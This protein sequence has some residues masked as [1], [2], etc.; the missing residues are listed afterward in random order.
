[1][2]DQL[3]LVSIIQRAK[4]GDE[5]AMEEIFRHFAPPL[6]R[7]LKGRRVID[8]EDIASDTWLSVVSSL[9]K[10]QGDGSDFRAWI[11]STARRRII[12]SARRAS[13]RPKLEQ[14]TEAESAAQPS[15]PSFSPGARSEADQAVAALVECLTDEQRDVVLLRVLG[16]FSALEVAKIVGRSEGAIRVIQHRAMKKMA[17]NISD[18]N[19]TFD[20]ITAFPLTK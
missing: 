20:D 4:S 18:T 3:D 8:P 16:G 1:M 11:F 13:V 19:V 14:I 15:D 7:Y 10:F 17:E 5:A 2:A 9:S 6:L 12:D